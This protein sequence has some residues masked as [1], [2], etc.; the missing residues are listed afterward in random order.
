[1]VDADVGAVEGPDAL[2]AIDED[3]PDADGAFGNLKEEAVLTTLDP[4]VDEHAVDIADVVPDAVR[5][6][7]IDHQIVAA[8]DPVGLVENL[9][10]GRVV[11]GD[12]LDV[13]PAEDIFLQQ[14]VGGGKQVD[15]LR[16]GVTDEAAAHREAITAEITGDA[17][18]IGEGDV[19]Q[20]GADDILAERGRIGGALGFVSLDLKGAVGVLRESEAAQRVP[21]AVGIAAVGRSGGPDQRAIV[22]G[23]LHQMGSGID[24]KVNLPLLV[25]DEVGV[26]FDVSVPADS[27]QRLAVDEHH[28]VVKEPWRGLAAFAFA[29]PPVGRLGREE[30]RPR[31]PPQAVALGLPFVDDL[32]ALDDRMFVGVGLDRDTLVELEVTRAVGAAAQ[33]DGVAGDSAGDG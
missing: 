15:A 22:G 26:G 10:G 7:L 8:D 5:V 11:A 21:Y 4:V 31:D 23:D 9:H 28:V 17:R 2:V 20:R 27:L 16:A 14:A 32:G 24:P 12:F 30:M 19:F 29:A 6:R 1:M 18:A 3:V 13:V 33:D 25:I